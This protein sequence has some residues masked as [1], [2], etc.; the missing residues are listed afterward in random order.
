MQLAGDRVNESRPFC[1]RRLTRRSSARGRVRFEDAADRESRRRFLYCMQTPRDSPNRSPCWRCFFWLA[2]AHWLSQTSA[3]RG[4]ADA[5]V[6]VRPFGRFGDDPGCDARRHRHS[7][8]DGLRLWLI[9]RPAAAAGS[10]AVS[11]RE[12]GKVDMPMLLAEP[13]A[14][15][16][17]AE[18]AARGGL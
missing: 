16:Q 7:L 14:E 9:A 13:V 1:G 18:V 6:A 15:S 8:G 4:P 12:N 10:H 11:P 2:A 5:A 17:P 3:R